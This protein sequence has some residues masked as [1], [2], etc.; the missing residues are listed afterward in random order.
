MA[1]RVIESTIHELMFAVPRESVVD[2]NTH[3][4]DF[5]VT[6]HPTAARNLRDALTEALAE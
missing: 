6:L 2:Y 1:T 3:G 5:L 4:E